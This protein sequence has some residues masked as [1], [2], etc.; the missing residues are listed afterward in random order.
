MHKKGLEDIDLEK[1]LCQCYRPGASHSELYLEKYGRRPTVPAYLRVSSEMR[2]LT[3]GRGK[4][5]R[6]G[7]PH[8]N[9][10]PGIR[11][12]LWAKCSPVPLF[13]G[14]ELLITRSDVF[15][16]SSQK[17]YNS[18]EEFLQNGTV[19]SHLPP[20]LGKVPI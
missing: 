4:E 17:G 15:P 2:G 14:K 9:L 1:Q 5:R 8:P 16:F 6:E 11:G 10:H 19:I 12:C 13:G 18:L 7:S 20:A 3:G